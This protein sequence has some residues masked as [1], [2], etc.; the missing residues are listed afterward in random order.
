MHGGP[1]A[2]LHGLH[3]RLLGITS[4][5]DSCQDPGKECCSVQTRRSE[6][7]ES[8]R[9]GRRLLH[10]DGSLASFVADR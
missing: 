9:V 6:E 5:T 7:E 8:L 4:Q 10:G 1:L 3:T 2:R